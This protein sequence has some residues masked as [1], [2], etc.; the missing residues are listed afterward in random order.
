MYLD[1]K[2]LVHCDLTEKLLTG[3]FLTFTTKQ[4][5]T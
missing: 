2:V 5:K 1:T 3:I 4:T